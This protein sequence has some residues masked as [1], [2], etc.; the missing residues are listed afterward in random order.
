MKRGIGTRMVNSVI[1]NVYSITDEG[2][3]FL[4]NPREILLSGVEQASPEQPAMEQSQTTKSRYVHNGFFYYATYCTCIYLFFESRK[5]MGSQAITSIRNL[6]T[7]SKNWFPITSNEDYHFPGVFKHPP[8]RRM[9][10]CSD[11]T[12][13]TNYEKTDPDFM[14]TDIQLGKGK[15][16]NQREVSMNVD[17]ADEDIV[18]RIVPCG[19]VKLCSQESC[20]YV[21][22]T[23]ETKPC[24]DHLGKKLSRSGYCPVEF[25]YIKPK[26]PSDNRW[27]LTGLVRGPYS[28]EQ[29]LHNHPIHG[30]L[31]IPGKIDADIRRAIIGNP[32]LKT[33]DIV[34]GK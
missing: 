6:M 21:V 11:I 2:V 26:D 1:Y 33:K 10:Y 17:G 27:W 20:Q 14:Y 19:G 28:E 12:T 23:R 9:G 25:V 29:N 31:K 32:Q 5:G 30:D 22:S 7:S 34:I 15:A 3:A 4:V 18:Y 16:R 24:P 8:P 13:L